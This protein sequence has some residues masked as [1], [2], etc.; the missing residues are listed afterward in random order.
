MLNRLFPSLA[1][2][3]I[4]ALPII[5]LT[6]QSSKAQLF[7]INLPGGSSNNQRSNDS[8]GRPDHKTLLMQAG[9]QPAECV[10]GA[11]IVMIYMPR[12]GRACAYP[13]AAF[14]AG[15]YRMNPSDYS[16]NPVGGQ[17]NQQQVYAPPPQQVY[18]PQPQQVYAP[19]PQQIY[20]PP[21]VYP[22]VQQPIYPTQVQTVMV[23]Y[24]PSQPV[25]PPAYARI[26]AALA[27]QGLQ[28]AACGAGVVVFNVNNTYTA[29][30]YPTANFP[31]GNYRLDIPGV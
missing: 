22:P 10:A 8:G 26:N 5:A 16:I 28:P 29:C 21:P 13:T 2:A 17:Q 9:L 6:P 18:A 4:I 19:P 14:P 30:A 24:N 12:G 27:S 7:Q 20:A 11:N 23:T 25:P 3:T 15:A 31:A 1:I